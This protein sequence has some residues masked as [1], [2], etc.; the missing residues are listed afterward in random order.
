[1]IIIW[2][3]RAIKAV[4]GTGVF[5]C[6]A[7]RTDRGYQHIHP[8]RWFTVFFIPLV[9]LKE[10]EPYVECDACHGA[11]VEQAL[12]APTAAQLWHML[13]LAWRAAVA[14]LV[15]AA[16]ATPPV[17]DAAAA[18]LRDVVALDPTYDVRRLHADLAA[19]TSNG[20]ALGYVAPLAGHLAPDGRED[21][22]RKLVVL[23]DGFGPEAAPAA[24]QAVDAIAA[25]LQMSPAHVAGIRQQVLA[26]RPGGGL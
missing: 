9:P 2:G 13:G 23:S 1:M 22:I 26:W 21:V 20:A 17:V 4:I 14:H 12:L 16:G 7:C 11:F 25:A 3:W 5:F 10:L 24:A 18:F 15:V 8:R 6:P 19:F